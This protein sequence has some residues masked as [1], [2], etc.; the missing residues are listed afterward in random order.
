VKK[1]L[2]LSKKDEI[3]SSTTGLMVGKCGSLINNSSSTLY[4]ISP[5]YLYL[6]FLLDFNLKISYYLVVR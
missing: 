1:L 4:M 5:F 6:Y 2:A 3:F